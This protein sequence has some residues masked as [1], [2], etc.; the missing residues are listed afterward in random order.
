MNQEEQF[1][2]GVNVTIEQ[3]NAFLNQL[4]NLQIEFNIYKKNVQTQLLEL[5]ELRSSNAEL[6]TKISNL[7][8][9]NKELQSEME[10]EY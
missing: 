4:T 10:K 9:M 8:T 1:K 6:R 7:E 3:R 2:E 5:Q